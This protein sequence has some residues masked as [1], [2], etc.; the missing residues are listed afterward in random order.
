ML[1]CRKNN[2]TQLTASEGFILGEIENVMKHLRERP[3]NIGISNAVPFSL[4]A[5]LQ[6]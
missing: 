6:L 5:D 1:L 4:I 3:D 2:Q